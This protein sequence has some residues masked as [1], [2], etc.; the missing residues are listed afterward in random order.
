MG[1][2]EF[3]PYTNFHELNLDWLLTKVKEYI[4]RFEKLDDDFK[5]PG[6]KVLLMKASKMQLMLSWMSGLK[7]A[8]SKLWLMVKYMDRCSIMFQIMKREKSISRMFLKLW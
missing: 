3:F 8:L 1:A 6:L 7:M 2:F 5:K 4:E